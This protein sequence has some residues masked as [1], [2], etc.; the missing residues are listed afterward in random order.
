MYDND[1]GK[2]PAG[3]TPGKLIAAGAVVTL[4]AI[5]GMW[6]LLGDNPGGSP[7]AGSSRQVFAPAPEN[8]TNTLP[9]YNPARRSESYSS[10]GAL[11]LFRQANAG[12]AQEEAGGEPDTES[13]AVPEVKKTTAPAGRTAARAGAKKAAATA[14]PKLQPTR[15]F[16]SGTSR[17][18]VSSGKV[19][20]GTRVPKMEAVPESG[21][22]AVGIQGMP[23]GTMSDKSGVLGVIVK[24]KAKADK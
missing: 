15:G 9:G 23:A 5:A 17:I 22:G 12:Y 14:I 24:S 6:Y 8:N 7:P 20:A 4:L 13:A 21:E 2:K 11:D 1:P 19:S 18:Q 10:G 3:F 16:G